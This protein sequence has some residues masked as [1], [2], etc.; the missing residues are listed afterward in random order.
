[1]WM[2]VR[3]PAGDITN[4]HYNFVV[5]KPLVFMNL[6]LRVQDDLSLEV[7][8]GT[9]NIRNHQFLILIIISL[10]KV[11]LKSFTHFKNI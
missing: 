11:D 9:I 10:M 4:L 7:S 3:I 8:L 2:V 6:I 1:M 5:A